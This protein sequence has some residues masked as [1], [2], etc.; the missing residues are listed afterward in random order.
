M[1]NSKIHN[2]TNCI[3]FVATAAIAGVTGHA[4][5]AEKVPLAP[6]PFYEPLSVIEAKVAKMPYETNDTKV[7]KNW[8]EDVNTSLKTK[9]L[10]PLQ[11]RYSYYT[12]P[13]FVQYK[14]HYVA[15]DGKG[16]TM[17][18]HYDNKDIDPNGKIV[19][20]LYFVPDDYVSAG[21]D[22]TSRGN[23]MEN[24]MPFRA[25]GIRQIVDESGEI[26]FVFEGS[27]GKA[28]GKDGE[29]GLS[30]EAEHMPPDDIGILKRISLAGT[31]RE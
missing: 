24:S 9:M 12:D 21:K 3:S 8:T 25:D 30:V 19:N 31:P 5:A 26:R 27:Y 15:D 2:K 7:L 6:V 22:V 20:G 4:Q 13:K 1:K 29:F 18:W 11:Q 28:V 14:E 23:V 17:V 16:Y 10:K